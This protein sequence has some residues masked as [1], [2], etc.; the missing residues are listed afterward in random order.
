MVAAV[1]RKPFESLV[2][3]ELMRRRQ[4]AQARIQYRP[5]GIESFV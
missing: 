1:S 2:D 3:Q 5:S 4:A